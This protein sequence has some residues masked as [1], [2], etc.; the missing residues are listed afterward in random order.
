LTTSAPRRIAGSGL[1]AAANSTI[2]SPWPLWPDLTLSQAVSAE[3]VHVHSLVA[4][5]ETVPVPPAAGIIS[6]ADVSVRLHRT[7][8]EGA[9]EVVADDPHAARVN[10]PMSAESDAS[11]AVLNIGQR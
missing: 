11:S 10:A 6:L 9:V 8:G 5:I 3:T 2:P 7:S 4:A 1:R